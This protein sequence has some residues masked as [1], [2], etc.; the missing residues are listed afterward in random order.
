MGEGSD[1][2]MGREGACK[3]M[4]RENQYH[5]IECK[6]VLDSKEEVK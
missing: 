1:K 2:Q 5:A 6:L 4:K 3:G